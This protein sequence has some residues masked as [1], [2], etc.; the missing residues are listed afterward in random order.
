[1]RFAYYPPGQS[2]FTDESLP[3]I[4]S[5]ALPNSSSYTAWTSGSEPIDYGNYSEWRFV[6][7]PQASPQLNNGISLAVQSH[8]NWAIF[9]AGALLGISGGSAGRSDPRGCKG[10]V[11]LVDRGN[12]AILMHA[13]KGKHLRL[14]RKCGAGACRVC[15]RIRLSL[16]LR[17][18]STGHHWRTAASPHRVRS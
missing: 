7:S 3:V 6:S 11:R 2:T 18:S 4:F 17:G 10:E 16:A 8:D 5:E 1:M 13:E 14:F 15:G 9:F 12:R